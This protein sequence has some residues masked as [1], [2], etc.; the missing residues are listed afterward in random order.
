M[1]SFTNLPSLLLRM[2][3][4]DP[5][6]KNF[7]QKK[8]GVY[9]GTGH[10]SFCNQVDELAQQLTQWGVRSGDRVAL[11]SPNCAEWV[12]ADIAVLSIGA[13]VVPLYPTLSAEEVKHIIADSGSKLVFIHDQDQFKTV[14]TAELEGQLHVVSFMPVPGCNCV[15]VDPKATAAPISS[16]FREQI[17]Q[18]PRNALA[19]IVYT[20]GTTGNPKGVELSHGNFLSNVE[21][22]MQIF[23]IDERDSVLSFLPLSHVFE[24]TVGYYT[25]LGFC[26]SVYYAENMDTV[27][28]NMAEVKPTILIS[29]PRVYEKIQARILDRITPIKRPIFNTAVEIGK[30]Y[31]AQKSAGSLSVGIKIL[32]AL[33]NLLVY[34]SVHK[35]TGGKLRFFVSGG[36]PLSKALAE[37]FINLDLL[38]IEGYGMTESAPIIACNRETEYQFGSVGKALPSVQARISD[39]GELCVKGPNVMRQY[40]NLPTATAE[41]LDTDGWL[42]TGD[43][44]TIDEQGFI[45][46]IDRKKEIIVMSNGKKVPPQKIEEL[47]KASRYVSQAIVIGDNRNFLTA[48]IVPEFEALTKFLASTGIS[49]S[50]PESIAK[51]QACI[52]EVLNDIESQLSDCANYEKIKKIALIPAAFATETGELTVTLKLRRKFIA[53]KFTREIDAMYAN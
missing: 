20:S 4:R 52:T 45:R 6:R 47:L 51:H 14:K 46:I 33:A 18:I 17:A 13:V 15:Q 38:I 42:H 36:A 21:D 29:V 25:L 30:R 9:T 27:S 19:S 39:D 31:H 5:E 41:I 2:A 10:L 37:F 43:I 22:L 11:F 12:L 34:R 40:H 50:D 49:E 8:N 53:E 1:D 26:G 23:A 28:Q 35:R 7:F 32:H 44:A 3:D 48:L 16:E 24:R